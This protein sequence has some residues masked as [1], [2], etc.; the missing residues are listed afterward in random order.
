M[1]A[2]TLIFIGYG[3]LVN[4]MTYYRDIVLI[5][6]LV[7][8]GIAI[9]VLQSA[10]EARASGSRSAAS[11]RSGRSPARAVDLLLR[12]AGRRQGARLDADPVGRRVSWSAS[13][14]GSASRS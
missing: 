2:V 13:S 8:T 4:V 1:G 9:D 10:R 3:L 6:P 11:A 5:I 12:G 7:L 14:P